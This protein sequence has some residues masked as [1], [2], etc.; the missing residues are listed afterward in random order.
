VSKV[1][2]FESGDIFLSTANFPPKLTILSLT[3]VSVDCRDVCRKRL[4][5][6][7]QEIAEECAPSILFTLHSNAYDSKQ[8]STWFVCLFASLFHKL[9][10]QV[11][12]KAHDENEKSWQSH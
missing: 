2:F 4:L 6:N 8:L 1:S 3:A 7:S 12:I 9:R 5:K 11:N 10:L